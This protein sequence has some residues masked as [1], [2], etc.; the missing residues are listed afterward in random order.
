MSIDFEQEKRL[1]EI[2]GS[3]MSY[4]DIGSGPAVVLGHS[5][6]WSAQMWAPQIAALSKHCRVIVPELWGHGKSAAMPAGTADLGHLAR[7]HLEL[8]DRLGVE[9]FVVAGLSVGGMW[10]VELALQVPDRVSG[11]VL[12]GTFFGSEPAPSRERYFSMLKTAESVGAVPD[13]I[14]DAILPLFFS[15]TSL[16]HRQDLID[17]F[18]QGLRQAS[19]EDI[20]QSIVPLGRMIFGRRDG[21]ADLRRLTMPALVVTGEQ[22][23]SR[24]PAEGR[25]MAEAL[26]CKFVE[27]AG[28]GHVSSLEAPDEVTELL[29]A[30]I[31]K[32]V[33]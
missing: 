21:L 30:F 16:A 15:A 8:L 31:Q 1:A 9:N 19:R 14:V 23:R 28:A 4:L 5:Y 29:A 7:Q 27:L 6:L 25:A 11:L 13:A 22:D 26:G 2:G 33:P 18:R 24:P 3:T 17:M 10:G 32:A 12:L 20:V